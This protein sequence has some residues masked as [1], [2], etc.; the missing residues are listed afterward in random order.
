M[1]PTRGRGDLR[2]ERKKRYC[3]INKKKKKAIK[4]DAQNQP[5][6][7]GEDGGGGKGGERRA[8]F[9]YSARSIDAEAKKSIH[10]CF[11]GKPMD[12]ALLVVNRR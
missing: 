5:R 11:V 12:G 1:V 2:R 4:I 9:K 3:S 8:Y 6:E 7:R 10:L